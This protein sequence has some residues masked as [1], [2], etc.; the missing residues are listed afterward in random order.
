MCIPW[1]FPCTYHIPPTVQEAPEVSLAPAG[2]R[3]DTEWLSS[4]A[5]YITTTSPLST[6]ST[7]NCWC[8]PGAWLSLRCS[9]VTSQCDEVPSTTWGWGGLIIHTPSLPVTTVLPTTSP[10]PHLLHA[11]GCLYPTVRTACI[12]DIPHD[13]HLHTIECTLIALPPPLHSAMYT[14][15]SH[16]P[17]CLSRYEV[18]CEGGV[19]CEWGKVMLWWG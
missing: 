17:M 12:M 8:P 1:I 2:G 15:I 10:L 4:R 11:S 9:L 14:L 19:C 18:T 3:R 6:T 7:S 16:A 13:G 5:A